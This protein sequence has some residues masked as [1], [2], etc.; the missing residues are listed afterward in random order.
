MEERGRGK[1]ALDG[2]D[3]GLSGGKVKLNGQVYVNGEELEVLIARVLA[4]LLAAMG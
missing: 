2:A 3:A 1:L 4:E